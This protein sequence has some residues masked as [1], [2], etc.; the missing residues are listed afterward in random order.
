MKKQI[1]LL[2]VSLAERR[3]ADSLTL[4]DEWWM[5][6][7]WRRQCASAMQSRVMWCALLSN[8]NE[9][10]DLRCAGRSEL[11]KVETA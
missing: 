7:S 4:P 1:A 5:K 8:Q 10:S 3:I 6:F 9:F 11:A 2:M